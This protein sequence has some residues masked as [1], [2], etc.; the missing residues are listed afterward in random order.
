MLQ[1]KI[2][3]KKFKS[4]NAT[5]PKIERTNVLYGERRKTAKNTDS[6]TKKKIL[7]ILI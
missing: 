2:L 4:S 3:R 7:I 5:I 1:K 6:V